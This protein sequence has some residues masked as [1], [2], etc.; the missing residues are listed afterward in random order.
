MFEILTPLAHDA[1]ALALRHF[2]NLSQSAIAAK[3]PL[4]LVTVAD[5]EVEAM[6]IAHLRDAFPDDG[7]LGEEGGIIPGTSGR[8]WVIDPIDGTFNFVRGGPQWAVSIGLWDGSKPIA[9]IIHA[10]V[11][12]ITLTGGT[13]DAPALNGRILPPLA[14]YLPDRGS[15]GVGL[16]RAIPAAERLEML[17]FLTEDAGIMFRC[18]NAS[19]LALLEVATGEVDGH[20]GYGESVWDVMAIWPILTALG[21]VST[22]DWS[23]TPLTTKLQFVIGK[24]ALVEA[25]RSLAPS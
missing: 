3:G 4:D 21:A 6:I 20:I 18:C 25:C 8:I 7:I 2:G 19:T 16:G 23:K 5:Q 10:P 17:R 24:P 14:A 1:G 11:M 12:G 13:T 22:L 9:G 15:V